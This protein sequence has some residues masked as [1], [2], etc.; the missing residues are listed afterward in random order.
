[1]SDELDDNKVLVLSW[2]LK[3][4][5]KT[6]QWKKRWAVLRN[7]QFSYY[8]SS[9][10]HKPSAV[11]NKTN[12]LLFAAIPGGHAHHFAIYCS[13]KTYHLRVESQEL[14]DKWISA[15]T[16]VIQPEHQEDS[17]DEAAD[18]SPENSAYSAP[19]L[20]DLSTAKESREFLVEEGPL[21]VYKSLYSQW[22]KYYVIVT[23]KNL[24]M[25]KSEDKTQQPEKVIPMERFLDVVEVDATKGKKWCLMLIETKTTRYLSASTEQT[26]TAFLLALKAV[27]MQQRG[28]H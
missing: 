6:H 2:V 5:V 14:F 12:L 24:Y 23:N 8:K 15:L 22:K 4:S 18:I 25:C 1:M 9:S 27:I 19:N 13:K 10:E 16:I 11:I 26:M 3:K 17:A 20:Q 21:L 28:Q 7:C